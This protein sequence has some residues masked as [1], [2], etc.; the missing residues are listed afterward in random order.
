MAN[1]IGFRSYCWAIGTTSY[2]TDNFNMSIEMQMSLLKEF[3]ELPENRKQSWTGNRIF[4]AE[5]Y[6]FLKS[7]KFVKR[8]A[9]RPDKDAREKTSGLWDIG[10]LDHERNITEAGFEL[11]RIAQSEDFSPDNLLEIPKDS[12]LYFKQLLKTSN[13][14]DGKNVRPF[15]AFLYVVSKVEYLTYEEFTYLLPLCVD[16][17]TTEQVIERIL[18]SRNR[19][20]NYEDII[21]SVLMGMDNYQNALRLLQEEEVTEALICNIGINRKSDLIRLF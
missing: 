13:D 18:Y 12:Y 5:Y 17:E 7:R 2:R 15:V 1:E 20:L 3:R 21:L 6:E 8:D 19:N 10:L 4:Q 9:P 16:Q 14:V 11:I